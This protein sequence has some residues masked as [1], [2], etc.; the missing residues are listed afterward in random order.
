[1]TVNGSTY[2]SSLLSSAG[3]DNVFA[4]EPDPYPT[5]ELAAAV[6]RRPE[7]VLAPSEPYAFRETHRAELEQ[8][9]PVVFVD[10][11]DLFWWGTRTPAAQARIGEMA[12]GLAGA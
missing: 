4:S 8:V 5:V 10:G 2:G 9:A 3:L 11:R 7:F 1:M 6:A 12:R